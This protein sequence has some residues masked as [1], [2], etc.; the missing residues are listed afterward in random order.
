MFKKN[1]CVGDQRAF[2]NRDSNNLGYY[3]NEIPG[4]GEKSILQFSELEALL[5]KCIL[6]REK[7]SL[8]SL[9]SDNNPKRTC[10]EILKS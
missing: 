3:F 8:P 2:V 7:E 5:M 9:T 4:T 6:L 1:I 10:D